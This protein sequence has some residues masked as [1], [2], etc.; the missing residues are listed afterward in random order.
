MHKNM[1]TNIVINGIS[2][3]SEK[4][5]CV[6]AMVNYN[7]NASK[8]REIWLPRSV[9]TVTGD[10]VASVEDWFLDKCSLQ[11]A[12]HGYRMNFEKWL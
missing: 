9:V 3:E 4:A 8:E 5:I 1:R 10:N 12:F 7:D 6:R 11:N 2:K